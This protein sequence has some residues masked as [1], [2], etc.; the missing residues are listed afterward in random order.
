MWQCVCECGQQTIARTS[1]L[2]RGD[3]T[4]CGCGRSERGHLLKKYG[5]SHRRWKGCGFISGSLWCRI[6]SS[7]RKRNIPFLITIEEIWRLFEKQNG[8]CAISGV[9]LY[10]AKN[11]KELG[12]GLNTASL[13]RKDSNKPY[14]LSNVQWVHVVVNYMKQWFSEKEFLSWCQQIVKHQQNGM[15]VS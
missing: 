5:S 12:D 15:V 6:I 11:S 2:R 3:K 1:K 13:D 10:L 8:R 14:E 4:S 7:A 9:E